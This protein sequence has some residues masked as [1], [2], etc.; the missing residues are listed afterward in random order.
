MRRAEEVLRLNEEAARQRDLSAFQARVDAELAEISRLDPSVKS[1]DDI[2]M[3][4][5]G[6]EFTAAVRRGNS[7]LD[8]FKLAN[9]ERLASGGAAA[10]AAAAKQQVLSNVSG[11]D[12]LSGTVVP[13]SGGSVPV[14]AAEMSLFREILPDA[15]EAEIR[16]YYNKHARTAGA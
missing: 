12:H 8:A 15:T 16:D 3:S 14:P 11:K 13:R 2:M 6:V 1:L 5:A 4:P 7:Y 10:A 9:W